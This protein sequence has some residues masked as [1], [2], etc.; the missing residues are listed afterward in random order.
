MIEALG[1]Y[2]KRIMLSKP[3]NSVLQL[4]LKG[5]GSLNTANAALIL[6]RIAFPSLTKDDKRTQR[7]VVLGWAAET[8]LGQ[9]KAE[10]LRR[11][12]AAR[13][14]AALRGLASLP[15]RPS[16]VP[17]P[18]SLMRSPRS[19]AVAHIKPEW[20]LAVGL[21]DKA[22]IAEIGAALH[23]TYGWPLIP[24]S[25]LKGIARHWAEESGE[26]DEKITRI[27]G[28]GGKK[29]EG[30]TVGS[31]MFFDALPGEGGPVQVEIDVLTPHHKPYY[32]RHATESARQHGGSVAPPAGW[33]NPE[34]SPFLTF[35]STQPFL[36]GLVGPSDDVDTVVKWLTTAI[37]TFG[38]GAKTASGYGYAVMT[39]IEE[40]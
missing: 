13:R 40:L 15:T 9:G 30:G 25:A 33:V 2:G 20:R 21:G 16:P 22:G 27:L 14:R 34:P 29:G 8:N 17:E 28:E 38:V 19:A 23:G 37:D 12:T 7:D 26:S 36:A 18:E 5:G 31:V 39:E 1:P 10:R 6:R 32:Q 3:P 4:R 11:A 35:G 24:A